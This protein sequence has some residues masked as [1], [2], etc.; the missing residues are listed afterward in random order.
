MQAEVGLHKYLLNLLYSS[1]LLSLNSPLP[2]TIF[3]NY[4]HLKPDPSSFL[5]N[6]CRKKVSGFFKAL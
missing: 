3:F 5:Q 1:F 4:C 6:Y 2:V